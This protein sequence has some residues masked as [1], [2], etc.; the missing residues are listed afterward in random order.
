MKK[1]LVARTSDDDAR[2][3][4]LREALVQAQ[5]EHPAIVPVYDIGVSPDGVP[6]FTMKRIR[7]ATLESILEK[8]RAG[9]AET[10]QRFKTNRLLG[11]FAQLCL[12]ID[13]VHT[14]GVVHRDLKPGNVMLGEFGE[15]YVL[16]WGIAR[17][18][19]EVPLP[20]A[21]L[22]ESTTHTNSLIGTPGYIAPE[23]LRTPHDVD[24]RA[25][26]YSLGALLFEILTL[27]PLHR[28]D[29]AKQLIASTFRT[30][31]IDA[32]LRDLDTGLTSAMENAC[33]RATAIE[34]EERYQTARHLHDAI[35]A[36]L[37]GDRG[38]TR[39]REQADL[40][41]REGAALAK[42]ARN[43]GAGSIEAH[44]AAIRRLGRALALAPGH[45]EASPALAE[46]L[47]DPPASVPAHEIEPL[48]EAAVVARSRAAFRA[49][50]RARLSWLLYLGL[51]FVVGTRRPWLV[52]LCA[53]GAVASG[54]L[55][56][57]VSK[58][59]SPRPLLRYTAAA[60]TLLAVT[61]IGFAFGP[62]LVAPLVALACLPVLVAQ[63]DRIGRIVVL[64]CALVAVFGP[65][66]FEW[67]G[68]L[69]PTTRFVDGAFVVQPGVLPLD[70]I[71]G[72]FFLGLVVLGAL[73]T[74][75]LLVGEL[76]DALV[77][78][79]GRTHRQAWQ[80]AQLVPG[81]RKTVMSAR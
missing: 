64:G 80:I 66:I 55:D 70:E 7:G 14:R 12:A 56:I 17:A 22:P 68:V 61:P 57:V 38:A 30:D 26:V 37:D 4:F 67:A 49:I 41:A 43:G 6:S 15:V 31:A 34:P 39:D 78:A 25:D 9:D 35:Q 63:S 73:T 11:A 29:E 13:F 36:V 75:V 20:L 1:L 74:S 53:G 62:F 47:V 65:S 71:T 16:D 19:E 60:L 79:E 23:Q 59:A 54:V 8:L 28:G 10:T 44:R 32:R 21:G 40:L 81:G 77:R 27:A 5:L 76:R 52:A 50:G 51:L 3:R 46:L 48:A 69:P 72:P 58:M 33:K 24:G 42:A 45:P 2:H 18:R